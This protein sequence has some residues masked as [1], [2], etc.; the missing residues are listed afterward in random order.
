MTTQ[1]NTV[2]ESETGTFALR[3]NGTFPALNGA[4]KRTGWKKTRLGEKKKQII[5]EAISE[6]SVDKVYRRNGS[7]YKLMMNG[8]EHKIA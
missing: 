2:Y 6:Y 7:I 3:G 5:R 4:V 1:K 8:V